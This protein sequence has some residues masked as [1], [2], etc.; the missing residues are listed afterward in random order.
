MIA[1]AQRGGMST[2]NIQPAREGAA[3]KHQAWVCDLVS[4][5]RKFF[6]CGAYSII[7]PENIE[8]TFYGVEGHTVSTA[9]VFW[10]VDH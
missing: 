7:L 3:V 5:T 6:D 4:A 8:W 1:R 10:P 9:V 2:V